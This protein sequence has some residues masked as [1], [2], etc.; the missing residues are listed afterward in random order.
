MDKDLP[1]FAWPGLS[2]VVSQ[3]STF[4]SPILM[5]STPLAQ[6]GIPSSRAPTWPPVEVLRHLGQSSG[7]WNP[8]SQQPR[9]SATT[10]R[11]IVAVYQYALSAPDSHS[12]DNLKQSRLP[13]AVESA[14]PVRMG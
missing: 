12:R 14:G 13:V 10:R 6:S 1:G 7:Q 4:L 9:T 5:P 3:L 8:E 11:N 2:H